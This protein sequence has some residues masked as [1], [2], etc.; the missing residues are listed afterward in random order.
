MNI[1]TP[2]HTKVLLS[3]FHLNG[4]TYGLHTQAQNLEPT[5]AA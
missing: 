1:L 4:H 2:F 5:S 3:K